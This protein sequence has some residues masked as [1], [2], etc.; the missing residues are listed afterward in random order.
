MSEYNNLK[1]PKINFGSGQKWAN[2]RSTLKTSHRTSTMRNSQ[3][4]MH[5]HSEA[6][7]YS[8]VSY[9]SNKIQSGNH[10]L[11]QIKNGNA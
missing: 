4:P 11:N 2:I 3:V 6:M 7:H 9:N 5:G 1:K 8:I 10:I